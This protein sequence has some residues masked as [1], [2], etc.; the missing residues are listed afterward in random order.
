M[1]SAIGVPR[2]RRDGETKVRGLTRYVADMPL[3]G[4]LHARLVLAAEAPAR[5]RR[6]HSSEAL[7]VP[8]VVAVLTAADLPIVGGSG[9]SAEPLAREEIVWAGQTGGLVGGGSGAGA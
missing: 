2:R 7:A 3:H 6:L 5:I 9:R 4:L 1:G 8:G